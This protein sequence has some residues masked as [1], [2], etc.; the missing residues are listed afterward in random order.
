[1]GVVINIRII[2]KGRKWNNVDP[3]PTVEI[4]Y[5]K[6]RAYFIPV[7][8]ENYSLFEMEIIG[9]KSKIKYYDG[10]SHYDWWQVITDPVLK[11]YKK[12][13]KEPLTLNTDIHKYQYH[14]YNNIAEYLEG[15]S[16]LHCG[17]KAA[18]KTAKIL[19]WIQQKI[20]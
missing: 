17:G 10:G 2:N 1:M 9:S 8:E 3:E 11:D 7:E 12:L 19:D 6:G 5:E 18:L 14:V 20:D 13:E 15:K 16:D 4:I